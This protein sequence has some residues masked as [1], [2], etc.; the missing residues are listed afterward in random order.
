MSQISTTGEKI[1]LKK[2]PRYETNV[3]IDGGSYVVSI[4]WNTFETMWVLGLSKTN[5]EVIF[6][7]QRLVFNFDLFKHWISFGTPSGA[8]IL[9]DP[10][11][12]H[13]TP[14]Y[15]DIATYDLIFYPFV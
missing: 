11:N 15:E 8:L 12:T 2:Y 7:G 5:G 4:H 1:A 3:D 13:D 6:S 10:T 9:T 14:T